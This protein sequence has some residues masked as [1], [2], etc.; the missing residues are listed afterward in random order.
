MKNTL[1]FGYRLLFVLV[2]LVHHNTTGQIHSIPSG[3]RS[4]GLG[5]VSVALVDGFALFNNP[6][7]LAFM[8]H[9]G[10]SLAVQNRFSVSDLNVFQGLGHF[11][12]NTNQHIGVG[13]TSMGIDGF[14]EN[15]FTVGYGLKVIRSLSVG[16]RFNLTHYQLA[17]R[18]SVF[19]PNADL[20]VR[21]VVNH[22]FSVSMM[23]YNPFQIRRINEYEEYFPGGI[24]VGLS[25]EVGFNLCLLAE[26]SKLE[27][28]PVQYR[29]GIE[30]KWME[31]LWI[32]TGYSHTNSAFSLGLGVL[33]K[34][35]VTNVSFMHMALPGGSSG[36]DFSY[37]W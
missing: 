20:G 4:M 29:F 2:F 14:S 26:I 23:Y 36:V 32:R 19:I 15:H 6:S 21:Y 3:M 34:S 9:S 35:F 10:L 28:S 1:F 30:W 33:F 24:G 37:K 25:Y 27:L 17:E 12:L 13:L 22:L 7:A 8:D 18:G 31:H 11:K 16:V 5:G